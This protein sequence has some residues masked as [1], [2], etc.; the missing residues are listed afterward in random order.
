MELAIEGGIE[1]AIEGVTA[2]WSA[3][4]RHEKTMECAS[5]EVSIQQNAIVTKSAS[6]HRRVQGR[7]FALRC[8]G[9][10]WAEAVCKVKIRDS[11]GEL[12]KIMDWAGLTSSHAF[13]LQRA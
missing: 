9:N 12:Q 8:K 4:E 1:G 6:D 7:G 2:E 13:L 10:A 5:G 11:T 3:S